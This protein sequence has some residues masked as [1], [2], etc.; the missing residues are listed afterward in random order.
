MQQCHAPRLVAVTKFK[1]TKINFEGLFWLST[2]IIPHENYLPYSIISL[3]NT[4]HMHRWKQHKLWT[5]YCL[6]HTRTPWCRSI[7]AASTHHCN[8][9]IWAEQ[10]RWICHQ[11]INRHDEEQI[12]P[13]ASLK[14]WWPAEQASQNARRL[15][16]SFKNVSL[17]PPLFVHM[18]QQLGPIVSLL[19][20]CSTAHLLC[21]PGKDMDY[22]II[23]NS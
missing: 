5:C 23:N 4:V 14:A 13:L 20:T 3:A 1:T 22:I 17:W 6:D 9:D 19:L 21:P 2:K 12:S 10:K 11:T 16:C 15:R 18:A 7:A 8:G